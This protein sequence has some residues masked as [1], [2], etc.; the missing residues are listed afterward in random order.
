MDA[1]TERAAQTK[2]CLEQEENAMFDEDLFTA[3][4]QHDIEEALELAKEEPSCQEGAAHGIKNRRLAEPQ[5]LSGS[6]LAAK[7][8]EDLEAARRAGSDARLSR[9]CSRHQR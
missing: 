1:E 5:G 9:S 2:R 6:E 4:E 8:L 3:Q 7:A